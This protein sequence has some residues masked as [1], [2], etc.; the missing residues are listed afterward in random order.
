MKKVVVVHL[1]ILSGGLTLVESTFAQRG[2]LLRER[3]AD[4]REEVE[5]KVEE[6][7]A[8]GAS[9]T[10]RVGNKPNLDTA[11]PS[12]ANVM[13]AMKTDLDSSKHGSGQ[14]F[15]GTLGADLV[16]GTDLI[17]AKDATV[18]GKVVS[19]QQPLNVVGDAHLELQLTGVMVG[20][21]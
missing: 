6:E 9:D 2:D 15:T 10:G 4:I 13:V 5:K 1:A 16:N 11:I 14:V 20:T 17:A 18:Y 21:Q 12:S 3:R 19:T 7:D 8:K